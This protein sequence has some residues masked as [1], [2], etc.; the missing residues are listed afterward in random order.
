MS[1]R[2]ASLAL[3]WDLWFFQAITNE[4]KLISRASIAKTSLIAIAGIPEEAAPS[5]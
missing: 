4:Q 5:F 3:D 2:V 1:A